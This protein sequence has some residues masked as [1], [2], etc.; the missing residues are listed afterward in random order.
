MADDTET[1]QP[2]GDEQVAFLIKGFPRTY[3]DQVVAAAR[4]RGV[5]VA[6]WLTAHFDRFGIDG[7]ALDIKP[8]EKPSVPPSP[9]NG[10][11]SID[12]LCKLAEAAARL[13]E[14][15]EKMP[16]A[17]SGALSRRLRDALRT[18][19]EMARPRQKL[20]PAPVDE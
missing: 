14:Y 18:P 1:L 2:L 19:Q 9:A 20:L 6:V 3:R 8:A 11:G 10:S 17:V 5:S 7:I 16:R 4:V 12:D 13:A 15:R